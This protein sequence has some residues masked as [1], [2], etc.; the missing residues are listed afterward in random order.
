M[1]DYL[2]GMDYGTGGAKACIINTSGE[3]LGFSFEEYPFIHEKPG[4]SEH[5]PVLYWQIASRLISSCIEQSQIQPGEMRAIA[6][7]SALPSMVMVDKNHDPVERAYNLM[8]RR[9]IKE[10]EWLVDTFGEEKLYRISGYRLEDHPSLVNLLWEKRNRPDSFQRVEKALTIDGYITLKL[11]G[12]AVLHYSGASFYGVAYDLRNRRFDEGLLKELGIPASILPELA[13]C[14]D[15]IGKVSKEAA[16]QTGL[17]EGIPV[18]AGQV[19]CNASFIG[20]GAIEEGDVQS[21]LGTVGNF[22]VIFKDVDFVFSDIG[23]LMINIEYTVDGTYITVPTTTTGGQLIRYIRDT[24]S[25]MEVETER[26]LGVS[27]YDLLNLQAQKVPLGCD[28][29]IVLPFLMGERTPIWDVYSRGVVF[30]LSLNHSKGH[31]VRAMMEAVAFAMYDSFRLIQEAGL[32]INKPIV[33]NEGGAVSRLWRQIITD[34][35]DTP[36]VLVKR[37]TGAPFGDAILSGVASG[38]FKDFSVARKWFEG[39]EPMEPDAGN[40]DSYMKIFPLYKRLYEHLKQDF[41]DLAD[42]RERLS[43]D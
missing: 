31:L 16:E 30:G 36:I 29:L 28:G 18:A 20:A 19:D 4:W 14:T 2:L 22:G 35:F 5:D 17:T 33:L 9:A 10:V 1:A 34:V 40:H 27:S 15:I 26:T 25:Q 23:H 8:D 32:K 3:V 38:V 6:V 42:L 7:S 43:G 37:R 21:N 12:Q 41:R 39:I 13:R 24:F 11:T